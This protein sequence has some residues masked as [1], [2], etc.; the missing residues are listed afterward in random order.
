M[1]KT[2]FIIVRHGEAYGNIIR[3]FHGQYN[4]E[5]TEDGHIQAKRAALFLKNYKIDH[6]Y[7]SDLNR[8]LSTA[9]YIAKDRGIEIKTDRRLRE[10][11]GGKWENVPWDELPGLFP[12]SY[13]HWENDIAKTQMPDGESVR[14]MFERTKSALSDIAA[15]HPGE[16]VCVVTHGTVL[17]AL[18]C[19]WRGIELDDMQKMPWFDNASITIVDYTSDGYEIIDEGINRHLDG[20]STFGKQSW[21][22]RYS[23]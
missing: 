4:S 3:I 21:W 13:S 9:A 20:V 15:A 8:T 14:Q 22:Q 7:S 5:L 16:T 10:I 18:V 12:E 2:R 17:R 11:D 23:E 6:I 1:K 19:L